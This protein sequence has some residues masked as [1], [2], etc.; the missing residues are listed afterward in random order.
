MELRATSRSHGLAAFWQRKHLGELPSPANG[1]TYVGLHLQRSLSCPGPLPIEED[2]SLKLN[3][4]VTRTLPNRRA[5]E[6]F[7]S[8]NE[9]V[10]SRATKSYPSSRLKTGTNRAWQVTVT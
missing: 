9:C 3:C 6:A 8:T 2:A 1:L 7:W 4:T 10:V 5:V